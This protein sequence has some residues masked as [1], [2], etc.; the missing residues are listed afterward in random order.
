M[1][2]LK[3]QI[4]VP[5]E[6]EIFTLFNLFDFNIKYNTFF[7]FLSDSTLVSIIAVSH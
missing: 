7:V 4:F 2:Y 6:C 1:N 3:K 5:V